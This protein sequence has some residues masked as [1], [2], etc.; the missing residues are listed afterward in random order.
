VNSAHSAGYRDI[1]VDTGYGPDQK[2]GTALVLTSDPDIRFK[3]DEMKWRE[4]V[5]GRRG[6]WQT[7]PSTIRRSLRR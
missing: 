7:R 1:T 3:D 4:E 5:A 6:R 2:V